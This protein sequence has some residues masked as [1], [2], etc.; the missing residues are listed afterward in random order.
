MGWFDNCS[1]I[2]ELS[3]KYKTLAKK[4]HPDVSKEENADK[5]MKEINAEYDASYSAIILGKYDIINIA[6]S[7]KQQKEKPIEYILA[8]FMKDKQRGK[9]YF[10]YTFERENIFWWRSKKKIK[11]VTDD[12]DTW[13]NFRGGFAVVSIEYDYENGV[14]DVY[15]AK[16][17]K[18]V[19]ET[20]SYVDMYYWIHERNLESS[21]TTDIIKSNIQ[22]DSSY[23]NDWNS[24]WFIKT[25]YYKTWITKGYLLNGKCNKV[26]YMKVGNIIMSCIYP[27]DDQYYNIED[28]VKGTEFSYIIFQ[29]CTK[30]EFCNT[31]DVDYRPMFAD[32]LNCEYIRNEN[33]LYWID[34]PVVLHYARL[35]IVKFYQ[36]KINFK[37]RYGT[38]DSKV[39]EENAHELDIDNAEIIQD[40]LDEL[41]QDFV[42]KSEAMA[43]KGKINIKI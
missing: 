13:D 6:K 33:D 23:L 19:P 15:R 20:P 10:A 8:F 27:I 35:G 25:N 28:N 12:S 4:Y 31:H 1:N 2:E 34:N 7:Y 24:F 29:E 39:L 41:N 18:I 3:T 42:D 22:M 40:Y 36:S 14:Y 30:K 17:S 32:A 11:I 21:N 9:G 16:N 26:A 37:L 5:I 43:R 38:F